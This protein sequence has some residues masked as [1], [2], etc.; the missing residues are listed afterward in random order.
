MNEN[1]L[2]LLPLPIKVFIISYLVL[3]VAGLLLA[4]WLVLESPVFKGEKIEDQY[5]SEALQELKAARFYDNLMKAHIHH[6][7][8]IFMVFSI[9]GI[10][11]F[12]RAKSSIKIQIIVWTAITTLVNTLA[13]LIYSRILLIVFG[14]IYAGLMVY[15]MIIILI[16][17]YK[18]VRE[19]TVSSEV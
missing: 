1:G 12:T 14:S 16:D 9:T 15:M 19:S 11:V 2:Y 6:L 13:F 7:G 17:C 10:Y 18:P 5:S 4:F 3:I 8:H